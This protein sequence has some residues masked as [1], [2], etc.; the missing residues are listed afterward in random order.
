MHVDQLPFQSI[1]HP[2]D[3]SEASKVA[4][5]HALR[6][7][8][9][10]R[11]ALHLLHVDEEGE[12]TE[13]ARFPSAPELLQQWA[14]VETATPEALELQL[15]VRVTKNALGSKDI[16]AAVSDFAERHSCDL[17][18]LLTHGPTWMGRI[19]RGSVA[20]ASARLAHAPAP[21]RRLHSVLYSAIYP[22]S[23]RGRFCEN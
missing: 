18:V 22:L 14:M 8:V 16:A 3:Y 19:L 15:G 1:L 20:E 9:A 2:T 23:V 17:L 4:F 21:R 6:L 13:W 7:S 11:S 12:E 5:A 10:A